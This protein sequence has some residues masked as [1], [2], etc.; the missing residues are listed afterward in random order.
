VVVL[1]FDPSIVDDYWLVDHLPARV[2]GHLLGPHVIAE[3]LGGGRVEVVPIPHDC[4]DGFGEACWRRPEAYLDPAVRAGISSFARR[5]RASVTTALAELGADI[6]SGR[7]AAE[8]ADLLALDEY[9]AGFRLVIA[10]P[11]PPGTHL[12][13]AG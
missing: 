11:R 9:D 5:P 2:D 13:H 3:L 7:W 4:L 12:L 6:D 10:D 1:T 8:H